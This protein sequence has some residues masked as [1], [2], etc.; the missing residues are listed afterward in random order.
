MTK[1]TKEELIKNYSDKD[2][3]HVEPLE[4]IFLKPSMYLGSV[5]TP[6]HTIEEAVMN[7]VDEAKIGVAENIWIT[8][9]KDHSITVTVRPGFR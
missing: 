6:Q 1:L 9:H 5:E 8:L 4:H 2:V 7:S 3:N